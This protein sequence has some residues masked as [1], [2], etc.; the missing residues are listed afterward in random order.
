MPVTVV[1]LHAMGASSRM[2]RGTRES[3]GD[4]CRVVAPDLPGHGDATDRFTMAGA[5]RAVGALL[6]DGPA[7]LVGASLG[8]N[9][10]LEVALA[11]PDRVAGLLLA[12]AMVRV[13]RAALALQR[14]VTA[15]LPLAATS[16]VSASVVGPPDPVDRAAFTA[17]IRRAGKRTQADA[18]RELA[19]RDLV[20]RLP[21]VT[22]PTLLCYGGTDRTNLPS[23][24]LLA[25][26]LPNATLRILDGAGHL[27]PL[28]QPAT[29]AGLVRELVAKGS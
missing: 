24:A 29:C 10:A 27:W 15:V 25:E 22:A 8:A 14:A 2:W 20:P 26:H 23:A 11:E 5:V 28:Q 18:L 6:G 13:P 19:G 3:L 16:R 9:V 12:G 4:A 7:Y 21:T 17:D 1:L